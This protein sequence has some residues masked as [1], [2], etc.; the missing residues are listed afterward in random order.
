MYAILFVLNNP[1][2][3]DKILEAWDSAGVGGVTIIESTGIHRRSQQK[4]RIPMRYQFMPLS[5][6]VEEGNVT[7]FTVV[8]DKQKVNLCLE[9]AEEIVGDLNDPDTGILVSWQVDFVKG[10][11]DD[12]G[13]A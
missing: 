13:M 12:P 1:N 6:G 3:L 8:S 4:L 7:L 5:V 2:H 9:K 11:P 10:V